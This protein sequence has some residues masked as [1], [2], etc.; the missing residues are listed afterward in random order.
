L[1]PTIDPILAPSIYTDCNSSDVIFLATVYS[2]L[3][4]GQV[5]KSGLTQF[6]KT[7]RFFVDGMRAPT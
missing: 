2:F 4:L 7:D 3:H 6:N 1:Y 5:M